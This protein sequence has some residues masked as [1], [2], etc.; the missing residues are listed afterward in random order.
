MD[1][2]GIEA[3]FGRIEG[4]AFAGRASTYDEDVEIVL[5]HDTDAA[6]SVF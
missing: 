2:S 1:D 3:M 5:A 4:S 6:S